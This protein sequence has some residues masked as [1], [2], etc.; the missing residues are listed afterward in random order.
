MKSKKTSEIISFLTIHYFSSKI[1]IKCFFVLRE[2]KWTSPSL[3]STCEETDD[4]H[5]NQDVCS[6]VHSDL[7]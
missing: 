1:P 4:K 3:F 5:G 7:V 6:D 2:K